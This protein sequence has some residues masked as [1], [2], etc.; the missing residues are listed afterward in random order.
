MHNLEFVV[1]GYVTTSVAL[2]AYVGSLFVRAGRARRRAAAIA[3]R[4]AAGGGG[5]RDDP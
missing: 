4:V 2:G 3:A 1:A 5:G